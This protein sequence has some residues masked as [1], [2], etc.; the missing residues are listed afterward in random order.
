MQHFALCI[1]RAVKESH[2]ISNTSRDS[3][4][5]SSLRLWKLTPKVT[6]LHRDV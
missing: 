5:E 6:I 4:P 3:V 1:A 2:N